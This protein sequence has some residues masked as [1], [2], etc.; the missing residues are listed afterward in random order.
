MA[1][2]P[3]ESDPEDR[4]SVLGDTMPAAMPLMES[5]GAPAMPV[6][7]R[8]RLGVELGRGGMGRV[9]EAF[10]V[11]LGRTVALK[12]ALPRGGHGTYRRFAREIKITARLEHASIVAL[13]DSGTTPDGRP[14]YVMRRVSGRPFDELI[15]RARGLGERL[16]LLPALKA[17][18]DA[19]AHAHRRGVIHRDLK[20]ANILVGDLGETVVI[21][22]GLAKVIGEEDDEDA[23]RDSLPPDHDLKTQAGS[24]FG[25]PGFMAPE[26]ARGE[27]LSPRSDVYA[28]GATLYQLLTGV[29]PYRG[30]SATEVIDRNRKAEIKPIAEAAPEAPRELIAIVHKSLA[31]D[32]ADRYANAGALAEDVRRFLDGQLV[33]A[34]RYTRAQ[35]LRRFVRRHRA[36]LVVAALA[37]VAVAVLSWFSVHR[38]LIERADAVEGRRIAE[39]RA[40]ALILAR[41]RSLVDGNPT[42][43]L[44]T[45]KQLRPGSR[46]EDEARGIAA[47]AASRGVAWGLDD[48]P[49]AGGVLFPVLSTDGSRLAVTSLE[50]RLRVYDTNAHT[51]L[52]DRLYERGTRTL[53][54]QDQ[55][56]L[57]VTGRTLPAFILDPATGTTTATPLGLVSDVIVDEHGARV[58]YTSEDGLDAGLF[59][60]VT[61]KTLPLWTGRRVQ[62]TVIAPDGSWVSIAG[63]SDVAIFDGTGREVARKPVGH[64]MLSATSRS[65][66]LAFLADRT[67]WEFDLDHLAW[68][69]IPTDISPNSLVIRIAYRGDALTEVTSAGE[70]REWRGVSWQ[71]RAELDQLSAGMVTVGSNLLVLAAGDGRLH[72]VSSATSGE[73]VLPSI[74]TSPRLSGS[75]DSSKLVVSGDNLVMIYDLGSLSPTRFTAPDIPTFTFLDNDSVLFWTND[76]AWTLLRTKTGQRIKIEMPWL[77]VARLEDRLPEEGRA[78]FQY[79][80]AHS[81]LIEIRDDAA[82]LHH[83]STVRSEPNT[84]FPFIGKLLPGRGT[85]FAA[86][87]VLE[88]TVGDD[89]AHEVAR[90]DGE[91]IGLASLGRLEF[92][93]ITA[94]GEIVRGSLA[95]G[96]L[97]RTH[98]PANPSVVIGAFEGDVMIGSG[99]QLLR[100]HGSEV[101]EIQHFTQPVTMILTLAGGVGV[102]L[103]DGRVVDVVADPLTQSFTTSELL[104]R[105][106]EDLNLV[107]GG[108]VLVARGN[109]AMLN[110]VE[111]PSRVRWNMPIQHQLGGTLVMAPSS[112]QI[113]QQFS[114]LVTWML[115]HIDGDLHAWLDR[116]TNAVEDADHDLSWPWQTPAAPTAP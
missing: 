38:V 107:N 48:D 67:V 85:V 14:Y 42:Q 47:S 81:H 100:W 18:I 69:E 2:E 89:P 62:S 22:W 19:I 12:E 43:A 68:T 25:T 26:Q 113:V 36:P 54:L 99:T 104:P 13:Y 46:L 108:H 103:A 23:S 105:G 57:L 96:T 11:Q 110:V 114:G 4:S 15:A 56:R 20:P 28:L 9:V 95:T 80:E 83:L 6:P 58:V 84:L 49:T 109:A 1:S 111:L 94:R 70:V 66:K 24:V 53:W 60:P 82:P 73:L 65:R 102:R 41:A 29:P 31:A 115:P 39:E 37:A 21:D 90:L 75:P 116:Q 7:E 71:I 88:G 16:T 61:G 79:F 98:V 52:I 91:I 93:A 87:D 72:W 45:L 76:E 40:E 55:T 97:E 63:D 3:P 51:L 50:G 17:A 77:G 112:G 5:A 78:M 64:V 74:I 101:T 35:R 106:S 27:E 32:S 8:Y 33:A 59:D 34:H 30:K 44:A 10:D 86:H 92:A